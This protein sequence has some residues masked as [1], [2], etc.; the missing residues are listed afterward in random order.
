MNLNTSESL[1]PNFHVG[2][3]IVDKIIG[4]GGIGSVY[5]AHHSILNY[6][7]AIKVH[8]YFPKDESVGKAFLESASFLSQLHHP[9]IVQLYDYGFVNERAYMAM[10]YI[11]GNMLADLIPNHQTQEWTARILQLFVQLLS[12]VRYAHNSIFIFPSGQKKRGIIHGDIK[13]QNIFVS[14]NDNSLKLSDF[15][16]PDVQRYL[17]SEEPIYVE[18]DNVAKENLDDDNPFG[19]APPPA[20]LIDDGDTQDYGTP[21]YMPPEQWEGYLSETN[22][23]FTLG[24]T[25]YQSLT[26]LPP[27]SLLEGVTPKKVNPFLPKW[28]EFVI[29]KAMEQKPEDRFQSVAEIEAIFLESIHRSPSNSGQIKELI[30]GDKLE[31]DMSDVANLKGQMFIGKFNKVVA[32][33]GDS[34]QHEM[35]EALKILKEA[36]MSSG[37][38][39]QEAKQEHIEVVNQIG[40]EASKPKPNKTLLKALGDGLLVALKNVPDVIKAI[41]AVAPYLPK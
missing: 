23:I 25:L 36:I 21:E 41:A 7:A 37:H 14:K 29:L 35:A 13:P 6:P 5:L 40:E 11:D 20:P 19:E 8:E 9:N 1:P 31:I 30:M 10:E 34:G 27:K 32:D 2:N 24:A 3:Y 38:L 15:M 26:G 12:A 39:N 33:L 22:D 28:V 4:K 16:I 17:G 18:F